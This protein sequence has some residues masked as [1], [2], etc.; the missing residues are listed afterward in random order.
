MGGL[1]LHLASPDTCQP[2]ALHKPLNR[3]AGHFNPFTVQ[4]A[5]DLVG[6]ID[7]HVGL[8]DPLNLRQQ[9]IIAPGANAT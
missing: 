4:L 8:P 1:P 7:L 5:P 9:A 6:T 3:A 2:Q